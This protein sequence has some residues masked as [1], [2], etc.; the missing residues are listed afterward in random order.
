MLKMLARKFAEAP[1]PAKPVRVTPPKKERAS[2]AYTA[3]LIRWE[4]AFAIDHGQIDE[5]HKKIT[6]LLNLLYADW[7]GSQGRLSSKRVLDE[8]SNTMIKHFLHEEAVMADNKC[9]HLSEHKVVHRVFV[10]D[11]RQIGALMR[12]NAPDAEVKP[13]LL[14]L[15]R[16]LV[17]DH[18][19]TM[20]HDMAKY[21]R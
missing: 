6:R 16:R 11:L 18:V 17:V 13:Q 21:M 20:D 14:G 15:T 10:R 5:E 19:L 1:A 4:P 12:T 8:L 7:M 3:E 9:P 2:V